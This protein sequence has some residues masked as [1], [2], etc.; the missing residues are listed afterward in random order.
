MELLSDEKN[1]PIRKSDKNE[2]EEDIQLVYLEASK[3]FYSVLC[4]IF[5]RYY[6]QKQEKCPRDGALIF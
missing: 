2:K 1:S 6:S 5:S 3:K 4:W